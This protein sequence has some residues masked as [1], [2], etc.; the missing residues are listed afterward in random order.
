M[1]RPEAPGPRH[2][3]DPGGCA[4]ALRISLPPDRHVVRRE[5]ALLYRPPARR[6]DGGDR[7]RL[8]SSPIS[9]MLR[10]DADHEIEHLVNAF[11]VNETYFYREEHQLRCMTSD[12]LDR[13]H[14]RPNGRRA[15]PHLVDSLLDRRGALFDRDLADGEL[16]PGR[17]LQHR[18]R[19]LRH[20]HPR[21]EGRR[22]RAST[23]TRAL[24]RLSRP[25]H[26]ALFQAARRTAAIKSIAGLRNSI[27][28]T[29]ANLIDAQRHGALPGFRHHLLPQR[30]DLFRRCVAPDRGR[31][32]L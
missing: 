24:M 7:I 5:Q 12:L 30:A 28:F 17:H 22:R 6:A 26:R 29:R 4:A 32:P 20:R 10:S 8:R 15:D 3:R 1:A 19:R 11:T 2:P 21:A 14:P 25:T 31:E 16:E 27:Q 9:R 13:D 18:D 23:A